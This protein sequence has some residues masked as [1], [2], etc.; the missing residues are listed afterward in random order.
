MLLRSRRPCNI[1]AAVFPVR[2]GGE[3]SGSQGSAQ[4]EHVGRYSIMSRQ[5]VNSL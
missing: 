2:S 5:F 4:H 3:V 1:Q